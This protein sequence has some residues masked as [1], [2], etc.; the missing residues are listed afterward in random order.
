[1]K[2]GRKGYP[3]K[4]TT[5]RGVGRM[6]SLDVGI[7]PLVKIQRMGIIKVKIA[8]QKAA[9]PNSISSPDPHEYWFRIRNKKNS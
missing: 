3:K 5:A 8:F 7:P 9:G 4:I 6:Y 2:G 1:M